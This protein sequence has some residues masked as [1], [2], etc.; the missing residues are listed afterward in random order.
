MQQPLTAEDQGP[1]EPVGRG[2]SFLAWWP[3]ATGLVVGVFSI[4]TDDPSSIDGVLL[5]L[6]IP[7]CAY[8]LI[9]LGGNSSWTW[10]L[11]GLVVVTYLAGEAL[12]LPGAVI[13]LGITV[14]TVVG[15]TA[16]G[17]WRPPPA[18]MRWQPWGALVFLTGVITAMLLDVTA[19]KVVLAVGLLL[20]GAWDI[21]HWRRR[22]VVS[23]SLAEWCAALDI[24]LG[25][26]VLALV[27]FT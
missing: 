3:I 14:A 25:V 22:A 6:L 1:A 9:A 8:A 16:A 21:V 12:S 26:G 27:V 18:E 17:R 4:A 24:S 20:H 11:T 5:T 10:P 13:L 23:R 2:R 19:A 15:G 7:T